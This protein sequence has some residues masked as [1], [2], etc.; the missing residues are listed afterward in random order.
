MTGQ[1]AQQE[2][3]D[4]I[5]WAAVGKIKKICESNKE[6]LDRAGMSKIVK[7]LEDGDATLSFDRTKGT[8]ELREKGFFEGTP[9]KITN[10]SCDEIGLGQSHYVFRSEKLQTINAALRSIKAVI[11]HENLI[12]TTASDIL[13]LPDTEEINKLREIARGLGLPST[14]ILLSKEP[15]LSLTSDG[16]IRTD[17]GFSSHTEAD[18]PLKNVE[19]LLRQNFP[20]DKSDK[21][22][23]LTSCTKQLQNFVKAAQALLEDW[24]SRTTLAVKARQTANAIRELKFS[25]DKVIL[26]GTQYQMKYNATEKIITP[27]ASIL[28]GPL[29]ALSNYFIA[30]R[31]IDWQQEDPSKNNL[32]ELLEKLKAEA[33]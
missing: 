11:N 8:F 26:E 23:E 14:E 32:D 4:R 19:K 25:S 1:N 5:S 30:K 3:R 15:R 28:S 31:L 22:G 16:Q 10:I 12:H 20:L 21:N 27:T 18:G 9:D 7:I 6:I 33:Q 2:Q 24:V 29:P 13:K 17:A